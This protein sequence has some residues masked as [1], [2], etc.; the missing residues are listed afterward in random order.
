MAS[1]INSERGVGMLLAIDHADN[2]LGAKG[3]VLV[4]AIAIG[5][6]IMEHN[7]RKLAIILR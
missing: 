4:L 3:V 1:A 5:V 6:L 2:C 7:K